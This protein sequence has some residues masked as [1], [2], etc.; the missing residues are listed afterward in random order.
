M[1]EHLTADDLV[2]LRSGAMDAVALL[3]ATRH[4]ARCA[5]CA[6][7]VREGIDAPQAAGSLLA[8]LS[9]DRHLDLEEELFPYVDGVPGPAGRAAAE[10][11]MRHCARCREDLDDLRAERSLRR[12]PRRLAVWSGLAAAAAII[13]VV[14]LMRPEPQP[15]RPVSPPVSPFA[16]VV[17]AALHAGR[18]DPPAALVALRREAD[19]LRGPERAEHAR[20]DPAGVVVTTTRPR[21]VW[22]A[23]GRAVVSVYDGQT[24]VARSGALYVSAWI[25]ETPLPRG[26]RYAWEVEVQSSGM[27][28]VIPSTPDPPALFAVVDE[29]TWSEIETA[30]RAGDRLAAAVL[31]ARAG[32]KAEALSDFDAYL[33]ANPQ[34][35][36]VRALAASV[37]AW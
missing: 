12:R 5:A 2:D 7:S 26:R 37:R 36:Q 10:E 17:R 20:L 14:L 34:D 27:D 19:T 23:P 11:H 30:H 32:A 9:A 28:R 6:A 4:I 1:D 29:K 35:A 16:P 31:E 33:T 22:T 3:R 15:S 13:V 18:L 24:V 25:P 21:F 8:E